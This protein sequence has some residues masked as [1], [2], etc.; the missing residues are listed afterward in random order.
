MRRNEGKIE[1][2]NKISWDID[3]RRGKMEVIKNKKK[4]KRKKKEAIGM[5]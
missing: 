2:R 5:R 4:N 3:S 1:R